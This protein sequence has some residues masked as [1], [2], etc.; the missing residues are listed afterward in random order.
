MMSND[1]RKI[2]DRLAI[3]L[4]VPRDRSQKWA[5]EFPPETCTLRVHART[6]AA[7]TGHEI[8]RDMA[9]V[10]GTWKDPG[11][12]V[13][14]TMGNTFFSDRKW[15]GRLR[16]LRLEADTQLLCDTDYLIRCR[17]QN[18]LANVLEHCDC[19]WMVLFYMRSKER[20]ADIVTR[21]CQWPEKYKAEE[22]PYLSC[23]DVH[24]GIISYAANHYGMVVLGHQ[25]FIVDRCLCRLLGLS[26]EGGPGLQPEV[27]R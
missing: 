14:A 17:D 4:E 23:I 24:G 27:G 9:E 20:A 26:V 12:D 21:V 13:Y 18:A 16:E 8:A 5:R 3:S 22:A 15:M 1:T 11:E 10:I 25:R 7:T 6:P 2:T 19:E